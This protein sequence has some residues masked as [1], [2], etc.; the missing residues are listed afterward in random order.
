MVL[1]HNHPGGSVKPSQADLHLTRTLREALAL[2]D[3][4]VRDHIIVA[5]GQYLS[6]AEDGL[7]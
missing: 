2:V 5:Q 1:A 7:L 6:M 4:A 3:V